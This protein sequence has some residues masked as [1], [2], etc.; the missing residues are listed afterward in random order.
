MDIGDIIYLLLA[1]VL[2]LI[3]VLKKRKAQAEED[4]MPYDEEEEAWP[5]K[6]ANPFDEIF[7]DF[8]LYEEEEPETQIE[9][10]QVISETK[11]TESGTIEQEKPFVAPTLNE[12]LKKSNHNNI[13]ASKKIP[14]KE[15]EKPGKEE[16]K[17]ISKKVP[18][19]KSEFDLRK[20]VIYSEILNRKY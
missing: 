10:Q 5:Q 6:Q 8:T 14:P 11:K 20:A 18:P 19:I 16:E 1:L 12:Y 9:E 7:K 3:S 13:A 15:K 4:E 17:K 2:G